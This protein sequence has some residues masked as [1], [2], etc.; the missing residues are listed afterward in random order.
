M[1]V[2]NSVAWGMAK[3]KRSQKKEIRKPKKEK[4]KQDPATIRG[5]QGG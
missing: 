3:G 2:R 4:V 1:R 5:K